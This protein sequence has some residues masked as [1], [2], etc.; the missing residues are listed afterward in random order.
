MSAMRQ[1]PITFSSRDIHSLI[2]G[3]SANN[4]WQNPAMTLDL[5]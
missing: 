1:A 2:C 3:N 5:F 4:K